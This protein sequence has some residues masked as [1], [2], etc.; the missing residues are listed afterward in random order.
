MA[1]EAL[2]IRASFPDLWKINAL[3]SLLPEAEGGPSIG[4]TELT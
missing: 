2:Q 3:P 1:G 4:G